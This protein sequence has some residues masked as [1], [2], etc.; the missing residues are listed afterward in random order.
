MDA[1]AEEKILADVNLLFERKDLPRIRHALCRHAL[2]DAV[3]ST[4]RSADWLRRN[5][6]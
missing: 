6:A 3:D 2:A 4:T 5:G 1:S